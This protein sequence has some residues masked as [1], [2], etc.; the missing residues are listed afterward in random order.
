MERDKNQKYISGFMKNFDRLLF[1]TAGVPLSTPERNTLNGISYVK[2]LGLSTMEL[3]FV[4]NINI[5]KELAKEVKKTAEKEGVTLTCHGQYFI[6]L[7]SKEKE[8]KDASVQRILNAARRAYECGAVSMTFHAAFYQG[9]D[10]KKVY[11]VVKES[12]KNITKTLKNEG[13]NIWVRP[14]TTGKPTQF[15]DIYELAKLSSEI[16][17]VMPTIDFA[18]LHARTGGKNNTYQEF[19]EILNIVEKHLGKD[20]LNNMHIHMAGINYTDKGERNHLNLKESDF[21]Y[22]DLISAWHEYKIKGVVISESPNIE[23]DA[24]LLKKEYDSNKKM[25]EHDSVTPDF[26]TS[27][28]AKKEYSPYK[29][30]R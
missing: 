28:K 8:K 22:K 7:N 21:N 27:Q 12:L 19:C 9:D 11:E 16:D 24:I 26:K 14:E 18:H 6:N 5:G 20:G 3:E 15:G 30:G 13:V 17:N 29:A 10:S 25:F 2:A 1:G 4:R 23:N